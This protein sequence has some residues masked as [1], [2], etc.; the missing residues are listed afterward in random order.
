MKNYNFTD[1]AGTGKKLS[2]DE[3]RD[4]LVARGV[5]KDVAAANALLD[6]PDKTEFTIPAKGKELGGTVAVTA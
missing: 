2:R 5:A 4:L 1:S 3:L 6:D